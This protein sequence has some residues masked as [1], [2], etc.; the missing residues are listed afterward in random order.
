MFR[1]QNSNCA[2]G[3]A[4]FWAGYLSERRWIGSEKCMA[5]FLSFSV[6]N[7]HERKKKSKSNGIKSDPHWKRP[8]SGSE[9]IN[10]KLSNSAAITTR[11]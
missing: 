9:K 2:Y 3:E 7:E 10:P 11:E 8:D 6:K 1:G 5:N 4:D